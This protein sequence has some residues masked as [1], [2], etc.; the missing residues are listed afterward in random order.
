MSTKISFS[1]NSGTVGKP[2]SLT[3]FFAAVPCIFLLSVFLFTTAISWIEAGMLNVHHNVSSSG[4]FCKE[5]ASFAVSAPQRRLV[6]E[7]IGTGILK[8]TLKS[9][10][11]LTGTVEI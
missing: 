7:N 3:K 5:C 9:V 6:F 1:L 10:F 11:F 2:T 4:W 8:Q